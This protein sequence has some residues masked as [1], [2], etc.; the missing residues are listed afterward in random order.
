VLRG[1][2]LGNV[3]RRRELSRDTSTAFGKKREHSSARSV[4]ERVERPVE[5][6]G[7]TY[8]HMAMYNTP[9]HAPASRR[10]LEISSHRP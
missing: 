9:R 2:G 3:E 7:I 8:S 4:S 6:M 5:R 1:G 10:D